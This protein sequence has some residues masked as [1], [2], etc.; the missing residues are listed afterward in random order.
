MK[1]ATAEKL[2][3]SFFLVGLLSAITGVVFSMLKLPYAILF[4]LGFVGC[5]GASVI[6]ILVSVWTSK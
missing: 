3:F 2:V 1:V 6:T 4:G 5:I